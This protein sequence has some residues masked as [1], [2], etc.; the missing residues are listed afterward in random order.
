[1]L[2]SFIKSREEKIQ[3]ALAA[4]DLAEARRLV[5]GGSNGIDRFTDAYTI[6]NSLIPAS[7]SADV[8]SGSA[9]A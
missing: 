1:L 3:A 2:A 8:R 9:S 7:V 5:N 6:G 4:G